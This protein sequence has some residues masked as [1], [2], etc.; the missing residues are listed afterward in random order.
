MIN[1]KLLTIGRRVT[2]EYIVNNLLELNIEYS[3][4]HLYNKYTDL[5][6]C[7]IW[8]TNSTSK[9]SIFLQKKSNCTVYIYI[10]IHLCNIQLMLS[11]SDAVQVLCYCLY[12]Y[13]H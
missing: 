11:E 5:I 4:K 3:I 12:L 9:H 2:M 8:S 6:A 7:L 1:E 13:C 10:V